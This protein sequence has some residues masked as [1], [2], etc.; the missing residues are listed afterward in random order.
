MTLALALTTLCQAQSRKVINLPSWD[1]SRDGKAW[2]HPNVNEQI[3]NFITS[4]YDI[5]L[6]NSFAHSAFI[7]DTDKREIQPLEPTH[8]YSLPGKNISFAQ[9]EDIFLKL[10]AFSYYLPV[11]MNKRRFELITELAK[12]PL[13]Y[14]LPLYPNNPKGG[15][16][17]LILGVDS[18]RGYAEFMFYTEVSQVNKYQ[19]ACL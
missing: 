15:S 19:L 10:A 4:C 6:R 7:I 16:V 1:F 5:D 13:D 14:K 11:E 9:W 8:C 3:R 18:R 12:T 17:D 2:S